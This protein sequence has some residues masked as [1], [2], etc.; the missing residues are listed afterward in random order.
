MLDQMSSLP[1]PSPAEQ[2]ALTIAR[3]HDPQEPYLPGG[4]AL[5]GAHYAQLERLVYLSKPIR[6][7]AGY[8]GFS[9]WMTLLAGG[10]SIPFALRNMPMLG[11]SIVLAAIG[12]RE[13]TLRRRL[14]A[15]DI[16][17]ARKLAINQLLLGGAIAAYSIFM[18]IQAPSTSMIESAMQKDAMLT[19]TPELAGQLD[20]LKQ[21][22]LLA[23][24]GMYA[25]LIVMTLI[26]QGGAAIYYATKANRL[27]KLHKQCPD[28]AVRVYCCVQTGLR[29]GLHD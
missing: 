23:K 1:I 3:E 5:D 8:A 25:I 28:W 19:S 10:L 15:L 21:L 20:D 12:T 26:F 29:P 4:P 22:E 18:L 17:S 7:A 27:R 24:A 6:K 14:L 2:P 9:G 13:L 16:R 11:F